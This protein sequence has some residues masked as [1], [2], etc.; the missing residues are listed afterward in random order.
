MGLFDSIKDVVGGFVG[1]A[2]GTVG[3]V[4]SG[5]TDNTIVQDLQE[6]ASTFTDVA[7]DTANSAKEQGQTVI[8]DVTQ[9]LGL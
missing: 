5:I 3:D 9:N 6:H 1:D 2:Q 4:L 8:D 7:S